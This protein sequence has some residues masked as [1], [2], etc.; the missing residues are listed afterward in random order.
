L[1][2]ANFRVDGSSR[3]QPENRYGYFPAFSAGWIIS[4]EK[5][6]EKL[7]QSVSLLKLR[8]GWG[9]TGND[10]IGNYTFSQFINLGGFYGV[11]GGLQSAGSLTEYGNPGIKWESTSTTNYGL[12][13]GILKNKLLINFDV[14]NRVTDD[15]LFRLPLPSSFGNIDAPIQN[16]GSVSNKGWEIN[17]EHRNTIGKA[18]NYN[19]GLNI[20]YVK[21]RIE[22]LNQQ[23]S[24]Y[25]NS[26][27]ILREGEAINSF[28]GYIYDGLYRD[29]ADIAKYPRF[30][31]TG[32]QLGTTILRDVNSDGKIDAADRVVL[33]NA[34]TPYTFGLTGGISFKGFDMNFLFQGVSGKKVYIYDFGNRPGNAGNTNFWSEWWDNRYE[35]NTNPNGTWPVL[36]RNAPE[37]GQITNGFFLR[38]ASYIRL[39]NIEL[40]YTLP[41][42]ILNRAKIR[43]LR[44]YV[45]GQNVLTFSNLVK[46]IDPERDAL[47]TGN[48]SYPQTKV[49][50]FGV[51]LGL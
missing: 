41:S 11:G 22:K 33:G 42:T 32:F 29:S 37:I 26:R 44:F 19:V 6:F 25:G 45:T 3:F 35:K 27:F 31:S 2:E 21:N 12:D 13:L 40:G 1:L 47:S 15:I 23:E 10:R 36:K 51:N 49:I 50:T 7:S 18:F 34:N 48:S 17:L 30:S 46:Q 20:S 39:K 28:Y 5:F 38:D 4:K 9:K 24:I 43:T 8:A 14:F 16:I